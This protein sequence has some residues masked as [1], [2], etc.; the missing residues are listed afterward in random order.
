MKTTT[1]LFRTTRHSDR[2]E[3]E[4]RNLLNNVRCLGKLGMTLLIASC[5]LAVS[6]G[7][8]N[9]DA[10]DNPDTSAKKTTL[11]ATP[12]NISA[13]ETTGTYTINVNSN[14]DWTA[15]SDA[16]WFT[17]TPTSGNGN[18]KVTVDV[19]ENLTLNT[20]TAT[21]TVTAGTLTK[22]VVVTQAAMQIL[23]VDPIAINANHN[24]GAPTIAVTT[25]T[26]WTASVTSANTP[27]CTLE[28]A[29]T[30]APG[31][32]TL[33]VNIEANPTVGAQRA[34]TITV[35]TDAATLQ[36]PVTQAGAP[37]VFT[38]A[39]PDIKVEHNIANTTVAVTCN[40]GWTASVTSTTTPWCTLEAAST[41]APGN[42]TLTVNFEANTT[43]K[44]RQAAIH[45]AAG[46]VSQRVI[47]T[48]NGVPVD[49]P[50]HVATNAT[51]S[52]GN[53][54]VWSD[55]IHVPTCTGA[56]WSVDPVNPKCTSYEF[57]GRTYYYYNMPYVTA[58]A[59]TMCSAPWHVPTRD[60]LEFVL[61][62]WSTTEAL[63]NWGAGGY[64]YYDPGSPGTC[65]YIWADGEID[66]APDSPG[67]G[68]PYASIRCW[69]QSYT[70]GTS[71]HTGA[72]V[73]CVR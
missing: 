53:D 15:A 41:S 6:C 20:R 17:L 26:A 69:G 5:L 47:V 2:S 10:D 39:P 73:L 72:R 1:K 43:D 42:G 49:P 57:G 14:T 35:T 55:F 28:A 25:K 3:A 23:S 64:F 27:W 16:T 66:E 38:L 4:R 46:T 56:E 36:V 59:N 48:Q 32:G 62:Y 68:D 60:E 54:N 31:N 18:T 65:Q 63:E 40:T 37:L 50:P 30:Y 58:N 22:S 51:M 52:I 61:Q 45:I 34:A 12:P 9:N 21:V 8:D 19:E 24:A 33:T 11:T 71:A 7:K 29:S 13:D 67:N 44:P 70:Q